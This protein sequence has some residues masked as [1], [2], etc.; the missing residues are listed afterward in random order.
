M[1]M[2]NASSESLLR[3]ENEALRARLEEAEQIIYALRHQ[4]VDALVVCGPLGEQVHT[5]ETA[6]RPYRLLVENAW[7]YAIVTLDPAGCYNSWNAGAERVLGYTE[8]EILGQPSAL[9][10]T[11]EDRER[12]V[13]EEEMRTALASGRVEDE[14]W[15]LRKDGSLFYA[16]GVMTPFFN[17][18]G[19]FL[20]YAK[21]MRDLTARKQA[22]EALTKSE[23]QYRLTVE[24]ILRL[25][26]F[27]CG[28][29]GAGN[30]L[31][32]GSQADQRL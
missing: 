11:R 13:P 14:R 18:H 19:N 27:Q 31:E 10:F 25:C 26:H 17:A 24:N 16:S 15:H 21:I 2:E 3:Q 7:D 23:E 8:S 20:G 9:I 12:C 28:Y 22:E 30:E 32:R 5:I 4:E 1:S 29:P 6:E